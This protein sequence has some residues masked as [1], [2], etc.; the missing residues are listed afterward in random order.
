MHQTNRRGP[1]VTRVRYGFDAERLYVRLD[2]DQP[3]IDLLGAGYEFSLKF[4]KP[5]ATRFSVRLIDGRLSAAIWDRRPEPPHWFEREAF[6]LSSAAAGS[7]LEMAL[8]LAEIGA[9][10]GVSF[11]VAIY[12]KQSAEIER[13]PARRPI[14]LATV[15]AR[16]E[17][18]NWTA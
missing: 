13:H 4:M 5:D 11:F 12:D 1:L 2:A 9:T 7:I 8:P 3:L 6:S 16:L 10:D 14:N 18:L 17:A 15:N